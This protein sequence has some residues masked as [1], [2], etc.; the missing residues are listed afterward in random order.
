MK[1]ITVVIDESGNSTVDLAGFTGGSCAKVMKDFQG[2]DHLVVE[3]KKPDTSVTRRKRN[4]S[5]SGNAG[6]LLM[7]VHAVMECSLVN[8]PG[9]RT[10]VWFQ[11]CKLSCPGCW[12][13]GNSFAVCRGTSLFLR[14][15]LANLAGALSVSDRRHHFFRRRADSPDQKPDGMSVS[16]EACSARTKCGS[17]LRVH[18]KRAR[19]WAVRDL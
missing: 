6:E 8:G 13:A 4:R 2:E 11:G 10:V 17:V 9:R 7:Q 14:A 19:S 18:R 5:T 1:Q 3:H 15:S 12:N 16:T